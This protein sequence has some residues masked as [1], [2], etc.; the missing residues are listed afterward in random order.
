MRQRRLTAI[1]HKRTGGA[2]GVSQRSRQDRA[3]CPAVCSCSTSTGLTS[4]PMLSITH[5]G[6]GFGG[7]S[8]SPHC[9]ALHHTSLCSLLLGSC[10][11][12]Y[13][14]YGKRRKHLPPKYRMVCSIYD[15]ACVWVVAR[16]R[17]PH[18]ASKRAYRPG[19]SAFMISLT[20]PAGT[21]A[22]P[23][24]KT[25]LCPQVR[26]PHCLKVP[27]AQARLVLLIS[28]VETFCFPCLGSRT[29]EFL[30]INTGLLRRRADCRYERRQDHQK[31]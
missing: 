26:V 16:K 14:G 7:R 8:Y 28:A 2:W 25:H 23:Q 9:H 15:F 29:R 5:M 12:R 1:W 19:V 27:Q 17:T 18:T 30:K 11:Q 13:L 6:I 10:V 3:R 21:S 20:R 4:T 22:P 24:E 31:D